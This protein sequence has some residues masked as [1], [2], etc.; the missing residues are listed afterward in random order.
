MCIFSF[1]V[2]IKYLYGL[3]YVLKYDVLGCFVMYMY[4]VYR[5]GMLWKNGLGFLLF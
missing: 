1:I 5:W 3:K 4:N 2:I